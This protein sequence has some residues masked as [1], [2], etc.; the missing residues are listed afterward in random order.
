MDS[1]DSVDSY[2][3]SN[4]E[5]VVGRGK[6]QTAD[7]KVVFGSGEEQRATGEGGDGSV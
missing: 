7:Q 4:E 6:A 5:D 3:G 2:L 1:V